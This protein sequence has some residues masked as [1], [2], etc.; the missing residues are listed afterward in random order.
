MGTKAAKLAR[1]DTATCDVQGFIFLIELASV[2]LYSIS[3]QLYFLLHI[4][5]NM[6][7]ENLINNVQPFLHAVPFVYALVASIVPLSLGSI[8]STCWGFTLWNIH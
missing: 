1:G 8:N 2:S 3:L 4:K 6:A 7:K 5:Y